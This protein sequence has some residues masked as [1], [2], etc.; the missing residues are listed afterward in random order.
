MTENVIY[1]GEDGQPDPDYLTHKVYQVI[2]DELRDFLPVTPEEIDDAPLQDLRLLEDAKDMARSI[3][4]AYDD[5][6]WLEKEA[7]REATA[8]KT[9]HQ[10]EKFQSLCVELA[11][12]IDTMNKPALDHLKFESV[13]IPALR[14]TLDQ[15]AEFTD[16][17]FSNLENTSLGKGR[18]RKLAAAMVTESSA[19]C[20]EAITGNRPTISNDPQTQKVSGP[21]ISFLTAIFAATFVD[22]SVESQARAFMEKI[23]SNSSN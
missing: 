7:Q 16:H 14:F 19:K 4:S 1:I 22:E 21:W 12:H 15:T 3:A 11:D 18:R 8:A 23:R 5:G 13:N 6:K 20:Y 9:I 2:I 10:L 17:A